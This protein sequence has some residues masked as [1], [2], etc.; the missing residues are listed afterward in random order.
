MQSSPKHCTSLL[1]NGMRTKADYH[2][3]KKRSDK[4]MLI[5][6]EKIKNRFL[7]ILP[8]IKPDVIAA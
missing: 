5:T 1:I 2:H 7:L 8:I 3:K 4:Y 6:F